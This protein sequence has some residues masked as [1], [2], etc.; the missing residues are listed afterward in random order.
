MGLG[1][2]A[3]FSCFSFS[4]FL[5]YKVFYGSFLPSCFSPSRGSDTASSLP[6]SPEV[7]HT[8]EDHD[9]DQCDLTEEGYETLGFFKPSFRPE[10]A[11]MLFYLTL[12]K[13]YGGKWMERV[14]SA[15]KMQQHVTEGEQ[16]VHFHSRNVQTYAPAFIPGR[17]LHIEVDRNAK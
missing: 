1:K 2:R 15:R 12:A 9:Q 16:A 11:N 4:S 13:K 7:D 10:R 3:F 14:H 5:Q 6:S 17:V 8:C